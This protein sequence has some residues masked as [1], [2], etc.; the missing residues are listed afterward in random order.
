MLYN[1]LIHYVYCLLSVE[2]IVVEYKLPEG[3][4]LCFVHWLIFH[5]HKRA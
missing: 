1:L 4:G 2:F 3:Q 5:A